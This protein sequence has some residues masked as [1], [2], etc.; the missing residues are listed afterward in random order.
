MWNSPGLLTFAQAPTGDTITR[1]PDPLTTQTGSWIDDGFQVGDVA[2][3]CEAPCRN[4]ATA[5]LA[6]SAT[7]IT[8]GP[9]ELTPEPE[10]QVTPAEHAIASAP[11]RPTPDGTATWELMRCDGIA[12]RGAG[13][14]LNNLWVCGWPGNGIS[15]A[16][17]MTGS[18][19]ESE[20]CNGNLFRVN[21]CRVEL[22]GGNGIFIFGSDAN[23]GTVHG[24]DVNTC[25]GWGFYDG[26]IVPNT[27]ISCHAADNEGGDYYSKV[28]NF[29]GCYQEGG[30]AAPVILEGSWLGG[31]VGAIGKGEYGLENVLYGLFSGSYVPTWLPDNPIDQDDQ[32]Q[33]NDLVKPT[34]DN[35][36]F[37]R[38]IVSG[39][40]GAIEPTWTRGL[41]HLSPLE[42]ADRYE[43]EDGDVVWRPEGYTAVCKSLIDF[44]YSSCSPRTFRNTMSN[45]IMEFHAGIPN[46]AETAF[47]WGLNANQHPKI[48][49]YIMHW[50]P[51]AKHWNLTQS[52]AEGRRPI[53]LTVE[54]AAE[55]PGQVILNNG[56]VLGDMGIGSANTRLFAAD[57]RSNNGPTGAPPEALN[58]N[59]G[60]RA[61][62][63]TP[64]V[65]GTIVT[66]WIC[67]EAGS[68]GTWAEMHALTTGKSV[69]PASNVSE[70]IAAIIAP[71]NALAR[72]KGTLLLRASRG[73]HKS[74][75]IDWTID[76]D[77]STAVVT[78]TG[79]VVLPGNAGVVPT[80]ASDIT[81]S[82][83]GRSVVIEVANAQ[84]VDCSLSGILHHGQVVT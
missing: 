28:S 50:S 34:E 7:V 45:D 82:V 75:D 44:H 32:S 23:V 30:N 18:I 36:F 79:A 46:S 60:D 27:F 84:G 77:G 78:G 17:S 54:G 66:G 47:G 5:I 24:V 3:L 72:F 39:T 2:T 51:V 76:S 55:G 52:G 62:N 10:C 1:H 42:D 22:C 13:V 26:G 11:A 8:V 53:A 21:N 58:W 29:F 12:I 69:T 33:L 14:R 19:P 49:D 38:C 64:T 40:R 63:S 35:G 67:T 59:V 31:T 80:V 74:F 9:G 73:N 4:V 71:E 48:G 70:P 43:V 56:A 61:L 16:A 65:N 57:F 6:V 20:R 83:S 41:Q 25:R 37:Y 15:V 68:P 81:A